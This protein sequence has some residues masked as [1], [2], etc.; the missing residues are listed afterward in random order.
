MTADPPRN[1]DLPPGYDETDPYAEADLSE[2][3]T[4]WRRNIEEFREYRMR[5]YRPPM[6]RDGTFLTPFVSHLESE[7]GVDVQLSSS[8]PESGQW[9][10]LVD[11]TAVDRV[12]HRREAAGFSV[13][14]I[15]SDALEAVVRRAATE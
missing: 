8:E 14:D 4:W 2:F 1:A 5:P 12:G 3:P 10:V 6:L 9:R 7:Y 13:F 11:G 15:D